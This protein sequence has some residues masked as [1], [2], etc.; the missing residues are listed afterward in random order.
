MPFISIAERAGYENGLERG[1]EQG[2]EQGLLKGI[3]ACLRLRFGTEGL[4]L[5][6]EIREITSAELLQSVLSAIETATDVNDVR[7]AMN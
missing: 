4:A 5:L 6:P 1:L 7:Q 2:L 3:E